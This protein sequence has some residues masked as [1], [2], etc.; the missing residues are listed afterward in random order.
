MNPQ[1][2]EELPFLNL[3]VPARMSKQQYI[4]EELLRR[5]QD[6]TLPK[7]TRIP[8]AHLIAS[9]W[10][11][12]YVTAHAA[13]SKLTRDGWLIRTPKGTF[14]SAPPEP[15][16]VVNA[17]TAVLALPPREDILKNGYAPEV[18]DMIQGLSTQKATSNIELRVQTIPSYP[19]GKE[20]E[21]AIK[22]LQKGQIA[23]FIGGQYSEII[24]KLAAIGHPTITL[25]N[26]PGHGTV[27][28]YDRVDAV[29]TGVE[30]LISK[31]RKRIG[32]LG[33]TKNEKFG[34]FQNHLKR[35][36]L[37]PHLPEAGHYTSLQDA[38]STIRRLVTQTKEFDAIFGVNYGVTAA[39]VLEARVHGVRIPDDLSVVSMGIEG[40]LH[41][42]PSLTYVKV[43]YANIGE[44]AIQL[45]SDF[46]EHPTAKRR[47]VT[48]KSELIHG[49]S[50]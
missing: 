23:V 3:D 42:E 46:L 26:D 8:N 25:I 40:G 15:E 43:P 9:Q 38:R 21:A 36:G 12:S 1:I 44:V 35:R 33:N 17:R 50:V 13:L 20:A 2:S 28:T 19:K 24:K 29:E 6:N 34:W 16:A 39:F 30:E 22:K 10:K 11:V 27:V 5:I 4:Y 45:A 31:G 32:F 14:V 18:F 37:K 49:A 48:V 41:P 47:I 7:G